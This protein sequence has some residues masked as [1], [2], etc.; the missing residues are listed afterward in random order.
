MARIAFGPPKSP[1]TGTI[2]FLSCSAFTSLEVLL[3]REEAL[4]LARRVERPAG[5]IGERHAVAAA[6][7]AA[8]A[9][10]VEMVGP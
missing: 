9:P 6:A 5:E 1:L 3:G 4:R 7:P 2:R 10:R 8:D